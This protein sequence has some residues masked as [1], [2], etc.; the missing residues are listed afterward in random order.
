MHCACPDG[1]SGS[2]LPTSG[3]AESRRSCSK[4]T[5]Q[6]LMDAFAGI[7]RTRRGDLCASQSSHRTRRDEQG[8]LNAIMPKFAAL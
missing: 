6:N 2:A 5:S 7:V 1:L 4:H 8:V 3:T